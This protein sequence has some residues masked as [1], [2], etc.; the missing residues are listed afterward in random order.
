MSCEL[1]VRLHRVYGNEA[2]GL[3]SS[4]LQQTCAIRFVDFLRHPSGIANAD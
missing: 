3:G 1:A 4:A 2:T